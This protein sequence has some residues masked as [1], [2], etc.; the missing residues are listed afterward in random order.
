MAS[1]WFPRWMLRHGIAQEQTRCRAGKPAIKRHQPSVKTLEQRVVPTAAL[2]GYYTD[3]DNFQHAIVA[4][5]DG[6][7]N[8]VFFNPQT[9]IHQDVLANFANVIGLAGYYTPNDGY[10]HAI[11]ATRDG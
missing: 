7:I 9:G 3:N 5:T 11:V 4:T 6:N 8:E 10:Q 1:H 2:A